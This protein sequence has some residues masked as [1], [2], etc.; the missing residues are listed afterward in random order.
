MFGHNDEISSRDHTS[1]ICL[2]NGSQS[3]QNILFKVSFKL[4]ET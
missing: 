3:S 1:Q 4:P 2:I